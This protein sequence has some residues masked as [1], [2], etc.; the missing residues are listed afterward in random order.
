MIN[1]KTYKKTMNNN[2][3]KTINNDKEFEELCCL[4]A[5]YKY[6]DFDAQQYGRRGQK[7]WGVDIRATNKKTNNQKNK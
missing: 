1:I 5:Q 6:G 2:P 4:I 7:Q 3:L